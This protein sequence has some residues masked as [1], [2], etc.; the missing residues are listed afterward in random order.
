V[1]ALFYAMMLQVGLA[2]FESGLRSAA[3]AA[4]AP[5]DAML[6]RPSATGPE[7]ASN[8]PA[9]PQDRHDPYGACCLAGCLVRTA[10][11]PA[12]AAPDPLPPLHRAMSVAWTNPSAP[13]VARAA[14]LA[15]LARGP[16]VLA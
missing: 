13:P 16:P 9:L 8:E 7:L 10:G 1:L 3:L 6:C 15:G 14:V 5:P 11:G 12:A 4:G 2:G